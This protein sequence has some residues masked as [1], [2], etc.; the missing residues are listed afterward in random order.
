MSCNISI[1]KEYNNRNKNII[2]ISLFK[3]KNSHR[4]FEV[5]ING[6][7]KMIEIKNKLLSNF[8]IV[9]FID[10][11]I[12]MDNYEFNKIKNMDVSIYHYDCPDFKNK[13][14]VHEELFGMMIRYIPIF[15]KNFNSDIV[16]IMD[17]D[18]PNL[19]YGAKE[20]L[21][22]LYK[23]KLIKKKFFH[24][25]TGFASFIEIEWK[26]DDH[27]LPILGEKIITNL[28]LPSNLLYDY[29][30]F[31]LTNDNKTHSKFN[32]QLFGKCLKLNTDNTVEINKCKYVKYAYG[33][34]EYFFNNNVINYLLIN[35]IQITCFEH[36]SIYSLLTGS[37]IYNTTNQNVELNKLLNYILYNNSIDLKFKKKSIPYKFNLLYLLLGYSKGCDVININSESK[38]CIKRFYNMIENYI[39]NNNYLLFKKQILKKIIKLKGLMIYDTITVYSNPQKLFIVKKI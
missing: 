3:I 25:I 19:L 36:Y 2:S 27:I 10:D 16:I 17:A 7:N 12:Y 13:E 5:Y 14:G 11:S 18:S 35:N 32:K 4:K 8:S 28:K 38:L 30:N 15:T 9:L 26:R 29:L 22:S 37:Y 6:L 23:F 21:V 39:I 1:I 33:I 20:S 34:D 31:L 24:Y